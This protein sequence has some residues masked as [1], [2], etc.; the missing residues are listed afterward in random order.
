MPETETF[1]E[2]FDKKVKDGFFEDWKDFIILKD[3]NSCSLEFECIH[4]EVTLNK[5]FKWFL[6]YLEIFFSDYDFRVAKS[7]GHPNKL[8]VVLRLEDRLWKPK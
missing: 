5:D 8:Q 7:S 2:W 3:D 6:D 1:R 4:N